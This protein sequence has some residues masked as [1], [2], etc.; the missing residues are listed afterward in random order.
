MADSLHCLNCNRPETEAP[1]VSLRYMG[2]AAWICSQ[3]LPVLIHKPQQLVGK[4]ANAEQLE[5]AD[6][7]D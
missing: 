1:L 3:C 7:E 4:L 2:Q 5:P 6:H